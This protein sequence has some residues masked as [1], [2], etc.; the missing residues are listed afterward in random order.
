MTAVTKPFT[1]QQLWEM[2]Q[3]ER[4]ELVRGELRTMAPRG[5]D[6]GAVV[7]NLSLLLATHVKQHLLG[8]VVG[9]ETGFR[10]RQNP[11]TV[12]GV[13]IG[14]V[15]A[16]RLPSTGRPNEYWPGAPDLAVEV[17]SPGDT[18]QAV[19]EKVDDYLSAGCRLVW[20]VNPKRRT[21]TV[22]R[23]TRGPSILRNTDLLDGEDV[24]PGFSCS[25]AEAF[26]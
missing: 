9:A 8:V 4:R 17:L 10:L 26:V 13:D 21:V 22:H 24:V 18:V 7:I 23:P 3:G 20:V 11:D 19:E 12:R 15:A 14:F 5:V 1:A 16:T 25:V 2:P 6:H